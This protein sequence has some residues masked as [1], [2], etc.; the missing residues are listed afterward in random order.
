MELEHNLQLRSGISGL[1]K[2]GGG[3]KPQASGP[4]VGGCLGNVGAPLQEGGGIGIRDYHVLTAWDRRS[5][6][7]IR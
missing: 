4:G 2:E 5:W 1:R 6:A 3:A 7:I